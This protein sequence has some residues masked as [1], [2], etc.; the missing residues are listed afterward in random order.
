[1]VL[2]EVHTYKGALGTDVACLLRRLRAAQ[3]RMG[4]ILTALQYGKPILVMPRQE[5]LKETRNDHQLATAKWLSDRQGISVV[6]DE[7]EIAAF[8]DSHLSF[9]QG[10]EISDYASPELIRH[11]KNFILK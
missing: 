11:L 8:L 9:Q 4:S 5:R 3:V 7:S 1:M 10:G 2:D 6:W